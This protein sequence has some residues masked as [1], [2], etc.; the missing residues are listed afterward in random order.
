VQ[1]LD[2]CEIYRKALTGDEGVFVLI[3]EVDILQYDLLR[4]IDTQAADD[5]PS[6]ELTLEVGYYL[7]SGKILDTWYLDQYHN[8]Q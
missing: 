8:E 5:N 6:V 2:H 7:L 1:E 4:E 3:F